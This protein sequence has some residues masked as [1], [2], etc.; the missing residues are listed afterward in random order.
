LLA[1]QSGEL[2]PDAVEP[3]VPPGL[4]KLDASHEA[5]ASFLGVDEDLIGAAAEASTPTSS[6]PAPNERDVLDWLAKQSPN[7][8]DKWL[9]RLF[10]GEVTSIATEMVRQFRLDMEPI[11]Q[12]STVMTQRTVEELQERAM[13]LAEERERL[14]KQKAAEEA[15]RSRQQ[16]EAERT[17]YLD[18]LVGKENRLWAELETLANTK[19]AKYYDTAVRLLRDLRD[20]AQRQGDGEFHARANQ[21]RTAHAH[22]RA[23]IARISKAGL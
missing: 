13:T 8:K 9:A 17:Q 19:Q 11:P 21:F 1:V 12:Q 15:E 3:P 22:Q 20:L 6:L 16:A 2:D 4:D 10:T 7:E 14:A 5:F 23:L 18:T